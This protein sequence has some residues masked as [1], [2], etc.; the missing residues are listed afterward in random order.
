MY[1][2]RNAF[3]SSGDTDERTKWIACLRKELGF[4]GLRCNANQTQLGS[5]LMKKLEV[6]Y[7]DNGLGKKK[8]SQLWGVSKERRKYGFSMTRFT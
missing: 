6:G 2:Y 5:Y 4:A 1:F 8:W 3:V 7:K